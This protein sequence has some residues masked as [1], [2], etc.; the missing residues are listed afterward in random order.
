MADQ[1]RRAVAWVAKNA[2]AFG[3]DPQQIYLFGPYCRP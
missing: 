2:E 3:G 1:V